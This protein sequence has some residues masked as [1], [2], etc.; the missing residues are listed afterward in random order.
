MTDQTTMYHVLVLP[1]A[2]ADLDDIA[3]YTKA[4]CG[5]HQAR[6]YVSG[7]RH[8]IEGLAQFPSMHPAYES[9]LGQFRKLGSGEHLI[10]YMV[11]ESTVEVVRILHNRMDVEDIL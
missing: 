7:L 2:E 1:S 6:R 8:D 3:I 4:R 10:F 11:C 5:K 9:Q